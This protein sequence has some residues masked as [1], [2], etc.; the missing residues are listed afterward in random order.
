MRVSQTL[1]LPELLQAMKGKLVS[2]ACY[3]DIAAFSTDT[4]TIHEGDLFVPIIGR[5]F[6]GHHFIAQALEKGASGFITSE[7]AVLGDERIRPYLTSRLAILVPD[8]TNGFLD[9][10]SVW[11]SKHKAMIIAVTGSVGK[12]TTKDM[13]AH[14][15]SV[16]LRVHKTT[17]TQNNSIGTALTLLGIKGDDEV[18][19]V[20]LGT[21]RPGEIE[22]LT[23]AANPDLSVITN[24]GP[25]H[26]EFFKTVEGVFKEKVNIL[27][28]TSGRQP[29]AVLN[30]DDLYLAGVETTPHGGTT[31]GIMNRAD[32]RADKIEYLRSGMLFRVNGSQWIVIPLLGVG[33]IYN[34]LA[35]IAVARRLDI[36]MSD[37]RSRFVFFRSSDMRLERR[38]INNIEFLLDCYNAN[39]VS[40]DCALDVFSRIRVGGRKFLVIGDMCELGDSSEE[41][42]VQLGKKIAKLECDGVITVGPLAKTTWQVIDALEPDGRPL[43]WFGTPEEAGAHLTTFLSE[44]DT[45]LIKGSRSLEL[46]KVTRCFISSSTL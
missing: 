8:T 24:V 29:F 34:A 6:N 33:N 3:G 38:T 5:R 41:F 36:A 7:E 21:S 30:A 18:A 17:G 46:E 37:I 1:T 26:L 43:F 14:L 40:M 32:V 19:V 42:H 16:R 31:F 35:A 44:G 28:R 15:L 20:E 12:T 39:P 2:Q 13:I 10:A 23:R 4:R 9:V 27:Q 45:V 11:R 25:S 22:R